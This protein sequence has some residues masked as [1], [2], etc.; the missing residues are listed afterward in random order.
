MKSDA[1]SV[2]RKRHFPNFTGIQG[3]LAGIWESVKNVP[4]QIP[5]P[6]T[7]YQVEELNMKEPVS[8]H[9]KE[10]QKRD[11]IKINTAPSIQI[12]TVLEMQSIT[13]YEMEG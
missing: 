1:L 13:P 9:Q 8:K 11:F 6:N 3:W 12:G 7:E 4:N 2:E 5:E 10:K